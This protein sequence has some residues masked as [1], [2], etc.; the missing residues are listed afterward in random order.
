MDAIL[1]KIAI[2]LI[3]PYFNSLYPPNSQSY[4]R[5]IEI[6]ISIQVFAYIPVE[7]F[8]YIPVKLSF[9]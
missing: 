1:C 3:Y 2:L 6:T 7:L 9:I 8:A 5:G 4:V